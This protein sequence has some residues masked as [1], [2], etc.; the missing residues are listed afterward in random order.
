MAEVVINDKHLID[1]ADRIR[2]INNSSQTYTPGEMA[3]AIRE[4]RDEN[5]RDYLHD[6]IV[7]LSDKTITEVKPYCF[8]DSKALT[9]IDL[10]K[11]TS[12][13][14]SAFA[15][16]EALANVNLPAITTIAPNGFSNCKALKTIDL[17]SIQKIEDYAFYNCSNLEVVILRTP[18]VC[19]AAT[20]AFTGT[21]LVGGN[22][23]LYVPATLE[24]AYK[25]DRIWGSYFRDHIRVI[26]DYPDICG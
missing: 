14:N 9:T 5:F 20:W 24:N 23:Y 22:G 10:R 19:Q 6:K 11:V 15:F 16:C 13:G 18:S 8:I 7:T 26:E 1:I 4:L 17:Y 12:I 3:S 21:P 25:N 2:E